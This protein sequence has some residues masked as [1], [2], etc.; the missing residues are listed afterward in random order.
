MSQE[1]LIRLLSLCVVIGLALAT[2]SGYLLV[3]QLKRVVAAIDRI[4]SR[5]WFEH[6]DTAIAR[7]PEREWFH[8]VEED[9][10]ALERIRIE[11]GLF[12]RGS[13]ET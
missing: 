8:R 6:V 4:P 5:E 11:H 13:V 7:I 12:H 9:Q 1:L 3:Q 2:A 10:R